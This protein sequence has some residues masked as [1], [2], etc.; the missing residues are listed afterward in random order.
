MMCQKTI[1]RLLGWS[2]TTRSRTSTY[3]SSIEVQNLIDP[4]SLHQ[5]E[6]QSQHKSDQAYLVAYVFPVTETR[7]LKL[8]CSGYY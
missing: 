7:V 6:D 2:L 1:E 4:I 5:T 8:C 3:P